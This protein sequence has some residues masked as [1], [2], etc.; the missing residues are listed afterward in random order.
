M[1]AWYLLQ[2]KPKQESLAYQHLCN[3]AYEAFLPTIT[4]EKIRRGVRKTMVE[5]LF[6]RY[7]F[8]RLDPKGRQ[9]WAPL[10]S[11]KGVSH[12]VCFGSYYAKLPDDLVDA[13]RYKTHNHPVLSLFEPGDHVTITE[14]PFT[15]LE[16]VFNSYD[17]DRRALVLI[18]W[19]GSSMRIKEARFELGAFKGVA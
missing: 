16:A 17:G 3:Q 5:P 9:S 12:L 8:V 19:L 10:R 1:K 18:N 2:S 13:L 4:V 6:N 14:G 15:G 11:T 7:L